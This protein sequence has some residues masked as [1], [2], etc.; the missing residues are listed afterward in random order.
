MASHAAPTAHPA[1]SRVTDQVDRAAKWVGRH[2][3]H[4]WTVAVYVSAAVVTSGLMTLL[5]MASGQ[6]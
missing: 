6:R 1:L 3:D 2:S 5:A 4:L